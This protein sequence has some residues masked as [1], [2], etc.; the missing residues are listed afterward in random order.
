M[1]SASGKRPPD[2]ANGPGEESI[3]PQQRSEAW[4]VEKRRCTGH[5][6]LTVRVGTALI[7]KIKSWNA[8]HGARVVQIALYSANAT[9]TTLLHQFKR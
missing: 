3:R 4:E 8:G 2:E 7:Q 5:A 9:E 1:K 6:A